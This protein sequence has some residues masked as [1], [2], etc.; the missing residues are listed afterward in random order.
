MVIF[1]RYY[2]GE[3]ETEVRQRMNT[4]L[5]QIMAKDDHQIVLAV[6][7]GGA[8]RQFMRVWEHTQQIEIGTRI[9]NC[10]IAKFEYEEHTFSLVDFYNEDLSSLPI[11]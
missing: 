10:A 5:D 11:D 3:S 4:I 9:Y 2:G 6:S 1:K 7:H 8:M